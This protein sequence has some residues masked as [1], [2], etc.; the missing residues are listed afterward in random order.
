MSGIRTRMAWPSSSI[1]NPALLQFNLPAQA[2][3]AVK[4]A[5]DQYSV[6]V[7][8]S[9]GQVWG[10]GYGKYGQLGDGANWTSNRFLCSLNCRAV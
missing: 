6:L 10:T 4:V 2:G 1:R 3:T 7:L 5:T 9:N 8:T